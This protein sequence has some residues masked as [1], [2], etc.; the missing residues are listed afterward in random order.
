MSIAADM[1]ATLRHRGP[2]RTYRVRTRSSGTEVILTAVEAW[3]PDRPA[4]VVLGH[5]AR[6]LIVRDFDIRKN[7]RNVVHYITDS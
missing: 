1:G 2:G 3:G 4:L 6:N 7:V 5:N